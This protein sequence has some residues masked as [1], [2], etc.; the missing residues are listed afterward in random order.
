MISFFFKFLRKNKSINMS[1]VVTSG[2][3]PVVLTDGTLG[4]DP[5]A[6]LSTV[7]KQILYSC[8]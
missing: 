1:L 3:T 5:S 8:K 4:I 6:G 7:V 2:N